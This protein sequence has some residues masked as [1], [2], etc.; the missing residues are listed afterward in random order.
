MSKIKLNELCQERRWE[1]PMYA[2]TKYGP[3]HAP[4][5]A[6]SLTVN[7]QVF[8]TPVLCKSSKE[9]Q[10]TCAQIA[11]DCLNA[12]S[13]P[14]QVHRPTGS[15]SAP[16]T[17]TLQV[18]RP[19]APSPT[20]PPAY[21]RPEMQ[22]TPLPTPSPRLL[23]SKNANAWPVNSEIVQQNCKETTQTS[24]LYRAAKGSHIT[25]HMYKNQLQQY[26]QKK[27]FDHPVYKTVAEGP[28]HSCRFK[29]S[30]VV[31]AKT[32][33]T[34]EFFTTLKEAEQAAAR[35]ACQMLKVDAAQEVTANPPS[36]RFPPSSRFHHVDPMGSSSA[37]PQ[38][39]TLNPAAPSTVG[40]Q[41]RL[42]SRV[43]APKHDEDDWFRLRSIPLPYRN[44]T[45][46]DNV[47]ACIISELE[48]E[49]AAKQFEH[50]LVMKF[51]SG[52][53]SLF[54]I[55]NHINIHW[56]LSRQPVVTL[57]EARHVMVIMENKEDMVKAQIQVSHRINSSLYRISRW[58][59]E[60]DYTK[61]NTKIPVWIS[62]HKLPV[63]YMIPSVLESIGGIVGKINK[64]SPMNGPALTAVGVPRPSM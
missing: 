52:R 10:N 27:N 56:G 5:F 62:L 25:L 37:G 47:P 6:A 20:V 12:Y 13:S 46:V 1:M 21:P 8:Y 32:Y 53:P 3:D 11:F 48:L 64:L 51:S 45:Y 55:K 31:R 16:A 49:E 26:C 24:M 19:Y 9:A 4:H 61:D 58:H 35:V 39:V 40:E 22:P 34:L 23:M 33:E 29:S 2:T 59:L 50:A 30:V 17:A 14:P 36:E 28:P 41:T 60:Y 7:G 15:I 63:K 42:Y 44:T 43:L 57:V 54:E 18:V 38:P